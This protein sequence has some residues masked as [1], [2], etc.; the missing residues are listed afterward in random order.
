MGEAG[1]VSMIA[2]YRNS[3][4]WR[5]SLENIPWIESSFGKMR[6]GRNAIVHTIRSAQSNRRSAPI[7]LVLEDK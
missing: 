6:Y 7:F 4:Q 1:S 3:V 5:G 2:N